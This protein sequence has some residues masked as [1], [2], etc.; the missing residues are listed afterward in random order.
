MKK[1][2][3][4]TYLGTNGIICSPVHLEDVYYTRTVRLYADKNKKLT[5]DGKTFHKVVTVQDE[6]VSEWYEV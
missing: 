3:L 4:Y 6:E 1:E 5:K 2:V